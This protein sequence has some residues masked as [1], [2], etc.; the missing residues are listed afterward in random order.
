MV[1]ITV[2][3]AAVIAAFVL[4]LGD[5]SDP[6]PQ[7]SFDYDYDED[8]TTNNGSSGTLEITVS[9]GDRVDSD[10]LTFEGEG[11]NNTGQSWTESPGGP[12]SNTVL[13]AGD[14]TEI[15]I[16][17]T[18]FELDIVFTSAGGQDSSIISTRTG[19]DAN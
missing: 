19:P 11:L 6:G 1:A 10:R 5:T 3:L 8:A 7:V 2:I 4:G 16:N 15:G 17:S 9:S 13:G 14:S 18:D 12:S